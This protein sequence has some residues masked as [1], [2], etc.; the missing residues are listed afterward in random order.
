[1]RTRESLSYAQFRSCM[2]ILRRHTGLK[3]LF[4]LADLLGYTLSGVDLS[5]MLS[6]LVRRGE[7]TRKGKGAGAQISLLSPGAPDAIQQLK[8]ELAGHKW[9][10]KWTLITYDIPEAHAR[11]RMRLVRLLH[12]MGFA[13]QSA[14]SWIS[15]YDWAEFLAGQLRG[16]SFGGTVSYF[17]GAEAIPLAGAAPANL[18]ALW[19]LKAIARDY[20]EVAARCR[21]CLRSSGVAGRRRRARAV[22]RAARQLAQLTKLDPMLPPELRP[23][24]WPREAAHEAF[25]RLRE[26]LNREI[27]SSAAD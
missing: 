26:K 24:R 9:D 25:A 10:G 15:P 1:M 20:G 27:G 21:A 18:S 22:L 7:I 12:E 23:G 3:P 14:S 13:K 19:D 6:Y 4:Y 17:R 8:T 11:V 16:W 5:R 2:S